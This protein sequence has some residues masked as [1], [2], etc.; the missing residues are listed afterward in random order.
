MEAYCSLKQTVKS[1]LGRSPHLF[2]LVCRAIGKPD[3]ERQLLTSILYRGDTAFDIGSNTGQYISLLARLVGRTGSV[4]AFE[5]I[6]PTFSKL[7]RNV[8]LQLLPGHIYLNQIA[9][10]DKQGSVPMYVPNKHYTEGS[11]RTHLGD[12]AWVSAQ[13]QGD[14]GPELSTYTGIR[15]ITLDHYVESNNVGEITLIKCDVEG[16]ELLVLKGGVKCLR[17]TPPML[18]LEC[19]EPWTKDFGYRPQELFQFLAQL[20]GYKFWHIGQKGL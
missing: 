5:P 10:G 17:R 20:A 14:K 13:G 2:D 9:L 6:P 15:L 18:L 1:W 12:G 3:V 8:A 7:E 19:Y 11:L 4:H 16:A